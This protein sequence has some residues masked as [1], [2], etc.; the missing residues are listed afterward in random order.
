MVW[1]ITTDKDNEPHEVWYQPASNLVSLYKS[2]DLKTPLLSSTFRSFIRPTFRMSN[3]RWPESLLSAAQI[4]WLRMS[5]AE[6]QEV[7]DRFPLNT[8]MLEYY[9]PF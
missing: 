4:K 8:F 9:Q 2:S 7:V 5:Q 1:K 3:V 6:K